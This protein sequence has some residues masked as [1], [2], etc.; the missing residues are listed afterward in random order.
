MKYASRS[1]VKKN[2]IKLGPQRHVKSVSRGNRIYACSFF[3]KCI[4]VQD[5]TF[6]TSKR[7]WAG[8]CLSSFVDSLEPMLLSRSDPWEL[9]QSGHF[10][11][12]LF[13]Q[14]SWL[15]LSPLPSVLRIT[16]E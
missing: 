11:F 10:D 9:S 3:T 15:R 14:G 5:E 2:I 8:F 13:F 7:Q 6:V 12:A 1:L 16:A 4:L